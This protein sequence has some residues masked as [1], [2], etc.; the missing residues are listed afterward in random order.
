MK[1]ATASSTSKDS[2]LRQRS[3]G[4]CKGGWR[5]SAMPLGPIQRSPRSRLYSGTFSAIRPLLLRPLLTRLSRTANFISLSQLAHTVY[6]PS[7]STY[8]FLLPHGLE[9]SPRCIFLP[10]SLSL[11]QLSQLPKRKILSS[12]KPKPGSTKQNPISQPPST[13]P[14]PIPS[15]LQPPRSLQRTSRP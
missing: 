10:L 3:W 8:V 14:P 5:S 11:F 12:T 6:S 7:A 4:P 1:A 9:F 15:A 2:C 13:M